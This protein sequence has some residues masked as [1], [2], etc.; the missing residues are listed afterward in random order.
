MQGCERQLVLCPGVHVNVN[1][2]EEEYTFHV[3]LLNGYVQ[4]IVA[5]V[6]VLQINNLY[7]SK[8]RG[9]STDLEWQK[10]PG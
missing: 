5:L 7:Y 10:F 4:E 8:R 9:Q 2:Q 3:L 6:I 1:T